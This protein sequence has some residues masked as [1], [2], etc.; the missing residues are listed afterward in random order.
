SPATSWSSSPSGTEAPRRSRRS[1]PRLRSGTHLNW[2][3]VH[4]PEK[5]EGVA[6]FIYTLEKAR[7]AH[8]DKVVLDDVTLS[9]LPGAK[10]GVLGVN[11]AGKSS[12]LPIMPG[13]DRPSNGEARLMPGYTVG[14]LAQEPPL[15]DAKTVLGNIEEAVAETKAKLERF[16]KIA[17]QMAT[18]YSD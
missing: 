11:G 2:A 10:I 3:T 13:L 1:D 8:G 5:I 6:Q 16:N 7:K 14:L 17:E 15:N 12:L 9:F 4:P 18:D